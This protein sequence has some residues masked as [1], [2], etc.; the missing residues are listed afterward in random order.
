MER[1]AGMG[2]LGGFR[3]SCTNNIIAADGLL[4]APDYTRTCKCAYQ[5][6]TSLALMH[7]PATET[8][9]EFAYE[10]ATAPVEQI[11]INFGA[12]GDRLAD[13]GV[14]WIEYPLV[15]G[16]SPQLGISVEPETVTY[17]RVHESRES[18]SRYAWVDASAATGIRQ[19]RIRLIPNSLP[20][21]PRTYDI[22][23]R[24]AAPAGVKPGE[25]QCTIVVQGKTVLSDLDIATEGGGRSVVMC[26]VRVVRVD[27]ELVLEL[28][29]SHEATRVPRLCGIRIQA[30]PE[31]RRQ[32]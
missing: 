9:T 14:M 29:P 25:L 23:L 6:Q 2:T 24:F 5:N 31:T 12:P 10:T 7:M 13:D 20:E 3:P 17:A 32:D 11:G 18:K 4:L 27:R 1:G 16:R 8:W 30:S 21:S 15:G 26:E 22:Q 28:R 19:F